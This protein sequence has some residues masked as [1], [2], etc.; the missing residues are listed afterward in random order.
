MCFGRLPPGKDQAAGHG[1]SHSDLGKGVLRFSAP[2][3]ITP[4][5]SRPS[6]LLFSKQVDF[7]NIAR[8][9]CDFH[10]ELS[11]KNLPGSYLLRR[12]DQKERRARGASELPSKV[13]C[14][15]PTLPARRASELPSKVPCK[16]PTLP[17]R[18]A[19]ELPSKVPCKGP[20]LPARSVG[21]MPGRQDRKKPHT[22][23]NKLLNQRLPQPRLLRT[24]D[25]LA[26]CLLC[27]RGCFHPPPTQP[28]GSHLSTFQSFAGIQAAPEF[29]RPH[30]RT[31]ACSVH[32][33]VAAAA[34]AAACASVS[35]GRY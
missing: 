7:Q 18:R 23:I 22:R 30:L 1:F 5:A 25:L 4:E 14:K 17:A 3:Y 9:C 10:S 12:R 24:L 6:L 13:P 20:T 8:G 31:P 2:F 19:S 15:G 11:F 16:G 33:S 26:R 29:A 34:A 28:S 32:T 35:P 21:Q 27:L